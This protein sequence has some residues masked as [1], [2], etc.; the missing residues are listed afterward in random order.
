ME[1]LHQHANSHEPSLLTTTRKGF[2]MALGLELLQ[3]GQFPHSPVRQSCQ[4]VTNK[5]EGRVEGRIEKGSNPYWNNK[6]TSQK[7]CKR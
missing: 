1:Q 7:K 6:S 5:G 4:A 3:L 2:P